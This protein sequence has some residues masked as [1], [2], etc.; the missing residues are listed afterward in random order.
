VCCQKTEQNI[1][2]NYCQKKINKLSDLLAYDISNVK[3]HIE[4]YFEKVS[5]L[6]HEKYVFYKIY[7]IMK[8][9][10]LYLVQKWLIW[11]EIFSLYSIC[12]F[13]NV[14]LCDKIYKFCIICTKIFS[15]IFESKTWM[16][17]THL[18]FPLI[19]TIL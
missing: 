9:I 7:K 3:Q 17:S 1:S 4:K 2:L 8:T 16:S 14:P 15:K 18:V 6:K 19:L 5:S 13:I 12:T 11:F 10:V